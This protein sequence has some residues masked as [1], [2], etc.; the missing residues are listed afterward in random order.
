MATI[1]KTGNPLVITDAKNETA[2]EDLC[3]LN[4]DLSSHNTINIAGKNIFYM[5]HP[6][7]T[8]WLPSVVGCLFSYDH[9][10]QTITISSNKPTTATV[11]SAYN[12]DGF[13][14]VLTL[15]GISQPHNFHFSFISDTLVTVTPNATPTP[16][17]G[18]KIQLC[19]YFADEG[20][21][22]SFRCNN[23]GT[24]FMAKAGIEYGVLVRVVAGYTGTTTFK[25]QVE[26]GSV[27]T[28]YE[29]YVGKEF[30][31]SVDGDISSKSFKNKKFF[32]TDNIVSNS[33]LGLK[34]HSPI[35]TIYTN[36]PTDLSCSYEERPETEKL[37]YT[38]NIANSI[39]F[40]TSGKIMNPYNRFSGQD[41]MVTFIDDDTSNNNLV[42]YYHSIME[43]EGVI[44]NYAVEID[45]L[46]DHPESVSLLLDYEKEGYGCYYHCYQQKG[47]EIGYYWK[48]QY[49]DPEHKTLVRNNF[50]TGLR[51]M[52]GYGFSNYKYWV[53]P[54]GAF[55]KF[56]VDL[57]KE[58]GMNCLITCPSE[59][60]DN[61]VLTPYTNISRW[62]IPRFILGGYRN[63]AP[64]KSFIDSAV[65]KHGWLV[66]VTH[67]NS[68]TNPPKKYDGYVP[69]AEEI[70]AYKALREDELRTIVQYAKNSG[71]GITNFAQTFETYRPVFMLN[72]LF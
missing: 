67:V 17:Y 21:I 29:P 3:L 25:P 30:Y 61:T 40:A 28:E 42:T 41:P 32:S 47:N 69:T 46:E 4:F 70:A 27:S 45:N 48:S 7:R 53:T 63:H 52:A 37:N 58:A 71:C 59:Y 11:F 8:A 18:E 68:F 49:R 1:T 16:E 22:T 54:F 5:Q 33:V 43:D 60:N 72:E 36:F 13:E 65:S 26:I 19:V 2:I 50:Y 66:I 56:L 51:K 55:D 39:Y 24:T 38:Y 34:M 9:N 12:G 64:C 62:R 23:E 20:S 6:A 31:C 14:K 44:G 10:N 35:T 15:N 57:A